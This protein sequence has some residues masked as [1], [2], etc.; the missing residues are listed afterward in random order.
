MQF[1]VLILMDSIVSGLVMRSPT[2]KEIRRIRWRP[3]RGWRRR[4][5]NVIRRGWRPTSSLHKLHLLPKPNM[6]GFRPEP[7]CRSGA[8]RGWA[9]RQPHHAKP[10]RPPARTV[11]H[12]HCRRCARHHRRGWCS[13]HVR[14][15]A[16]AQRP[17]TRS[18][19]PPPWRTCRL[20]APVCGRFPGPLRACARC[21]SIIG[22]TDRIGGRMAGAVAEQAR[23][24]WRS[25]ARTWRVARLPE[26]P[27]TK[28]L[29]HWLFDLGATDSRRHQRVL[30]RSLATQSQR[31]Q[32]RALPPVH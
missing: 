19:P 23:P 20:D 9:P 7:H 28:G 10:R 16:R 4:P 18:V 17:T 2:P 29:G 3:A 11:F 1:A 15:R 26:D 32:V 8:P 13:Q 25:S 22:R 30:L 21:S 24:D 5:I 14:R 6:C 27:A 12:I 31:R